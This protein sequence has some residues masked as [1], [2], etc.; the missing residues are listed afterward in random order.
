MV[1]IQKLSHL[2]NSESNFGQFPTRF[3]AIRTAQNAR[4]RP[5]KEPPVRAH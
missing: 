5:H 2:A 4:P 1:P 3:D